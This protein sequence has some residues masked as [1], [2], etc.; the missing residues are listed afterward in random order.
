MWKSAGEDDIMPEVLKYVPID[1][2][3][4]DIINK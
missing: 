4:L 2:I 3:V 1:D